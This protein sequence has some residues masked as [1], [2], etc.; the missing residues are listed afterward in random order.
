MSTKD[1]SFE[2][3]QTIGYI[4]A[5]PYIEDARAADAP[6]YA[7]T[8][9]IQQCES[10]IW[11]L[12]SKLSASVLG[13]TAGKFN[14][15]GVDRHGYV[16]R[17]IQAGQEGEIRVMGLPMRKPTPVKEKQVKVQALLIVRDWLKAAITARTFT[18][19]SSPLIPYLLL[20]DGRTVGE[21][22]AE[23]QTQAL[24]SSGND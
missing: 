6:Y 10:E 23:R 12:L 15:R 16:I 4:V 1:W 13:F 22:V 11:T 8:K 7:S 2:P 5:A 18:P 21:A 20:P 3:D 9:T 19:D 24:L 14:V 17:F